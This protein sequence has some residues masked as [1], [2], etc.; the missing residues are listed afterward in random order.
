MVTASVHT[1]DEVRGAIRELDARY[2]YVADPHTA[3]A[4]LGATEALAR[5]PDAC[6]RSVLA[7]AH[8][9]KFG[10]VVEPVIGR[11]VPVPAPLAEAMRR[12]RLVEHIAPDLAE[13]APLL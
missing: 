13:L 9:A 5:N 4:Y 6:T 8:P 10:D 1:D 2:G 12:P 7:T 3:I 11:P